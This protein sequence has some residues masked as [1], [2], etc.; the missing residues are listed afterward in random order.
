MDILT[1]LIV[2][3]IAGWAAGLIMEGRGFGVFG[4]IIVGI[5]GAFIGGLLFDAV[6]V[7]TYGFIGSVVAAIVGALILLALVSLYK[8]HSSTS[9]TSSRWT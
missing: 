8:Q 4:D 7:S 9:P 2:G 5:V 1:F 6:G 3:L